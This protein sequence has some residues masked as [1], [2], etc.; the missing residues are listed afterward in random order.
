MLCAFLKEGQRNPCNKV[1][2]IFDPRAH[3]VYRK[4]FRSALS[5]TPDQ[6]TCSRI[7]TN[8]LHQVQIVKRVSSLQLP[9][10]CWLELR[11][12]IGNQKFMIGS[13]LRCTSRTQSQSRLCHG[14]KKQVVPN[15]A[16]TDF[17]PFAYLKCKFDEKMI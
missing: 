7:A 17:L 2:Q 14:W 12:D 3:R 6:A 9:L 4:S 16:A 10:F 5:Y 11:S 8:K 15:K 1:W 13:H